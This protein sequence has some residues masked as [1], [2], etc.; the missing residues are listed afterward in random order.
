MS[1]TSYALIFLA[2]N[3]I[4]YSALSVYEDK[5]KQKLDG[6]M[7]LTTSIKLFISFLFSIT[8]LAGVLLIYD[9]NGTY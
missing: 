8:I 7:E 9:F 1:L 2:I 5:K 3:F 4:L 6:R